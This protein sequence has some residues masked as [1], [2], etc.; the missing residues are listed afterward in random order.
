MSRVGKQ[1]IPIP[2]QVQ[3]EIAGGE[4]RV[5]GPKG[6]L[7]HH[8]PPE[9]SVRREDNQ[10]LVSRG[11]DH[12]RQRSLH[13]LTRTLIANMVEGV[14]KGFTKS[15]ELVGTGYRAQLR[16]QTLILQ[17][18]FSHPVEVEAPPGITFTLEGSNRIHVHGIDKALVG[19]VAARIRRVRPPE[20]YKGKGILYVGEVVRRKAG[21]GGRASK[22]RGR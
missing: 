8:L 18:G 15:L 19:D 9:I 5:K 11:G 21:K 17:V 13:G 20:P 12:P 7:V 10:L 4:V 16:G 3:V 1:P 6:E 2:P 22:G 14:S